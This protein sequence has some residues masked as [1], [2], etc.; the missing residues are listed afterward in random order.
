MGLIQKIVF[1]ILATS[2]IFWA[3]EQYVF[4]ETFDIQGEVISYPIIALVFGLLNFF[5]KPLLKLFTFPIHFITLGLSSIVLN[6]GLLWLWE[7]IINFLQLSIINIEIKD[8]ITYFLVGIILA[9]SNAIL[10]WFER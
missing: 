9:I 5:V 1:H 4:P 6:A 7:Y 3:I 2:A 8:W 10:H